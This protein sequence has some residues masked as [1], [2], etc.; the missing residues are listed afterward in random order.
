M[1]IKTPPSMLA[2][3]VASRTPAP[4]TPASE[5]PEVPARGRPLAVSLAIVTLLLL[6]FIAAR[7]MGAP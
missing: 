2:L 1:R 5:L 3:G 7:T 4:T 6:L